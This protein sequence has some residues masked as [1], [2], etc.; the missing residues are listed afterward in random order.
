VA[1]YTIQQLKDLWIQAGGSA[2]YAD[3]AAAIA[4]AESGGKSDAFNGSNS[5]GTSDKGLWQINSIHGKQSTF[6]PLENAKAAV[7]IS[8]GGTDWRPWCTAWSNG[9]C[10]GTFLGEGSPVLKFLNGITN[11]GVLPTGGDG[12]S[13]IS[14]GADAGTAEILSKIL[15]AVGLGIPEKIMAQIGKKFWQYA[16][17]ISF[18]IGGIMFMAFGMVLIILSTRVAKTVGNTAAQIGITRAAFG[19][20]RGGNI[21]VENYIAPPDDPRPVTAVLL[22]SAPPGANQLPAGAEPI[23]PP[24]ESDRRARLAASE[25]NMRRGLE[26]SPRQRASRRKASTEP[27]SVYQPRHA[28]GE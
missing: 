10:G 12:N 14:I 20:G 23:F 19:G 24:L 22:T 26:K 27:P 15:S 17:W 8:K 18:V 5:N 4:M 1:Q 2:T 16:T 7:A 3:M 21:A 13:I 28:K 9:A 11:T 6:D 25:D